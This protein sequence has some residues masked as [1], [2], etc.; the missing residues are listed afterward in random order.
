MNTVILGLAA[1]LTY[2][3]HPKTPWTWESTFPSN[4]PVWASTT[5]VPCRRTEP[6]S[7]SA[8]TIMANWDEA[9]PKP[10]EMGR[11]K[12][13]IHWRSWIGALDLWWRRSCALD[14]LRV[15]YQLQENSNVMVETNS[16]NWALA[17]PKL[18][19]MLHLNSVM[20]SRRW[21]R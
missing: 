9:I 11:E 14:G 4:Q 16:A 17:P 5:L 15:V 13:V 18:K 7:A 2:M 12:W 8:G 21:I 6:Q 1:P 20:L 3:N 19:V 10:S